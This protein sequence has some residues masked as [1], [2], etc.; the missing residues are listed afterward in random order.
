MEQALWLD[1]LSSILAFVGLGSLV[2]CYLNYKPRWFDC[3]IFAV[4]FFVFGWYSGL[5]PDEATLYQWLTA[6]AFAFGVVVL[7]WLKSLYL[8]KTDRNNIANERRLR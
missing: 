6:A 8:K 2:V 3:V 5:N 1:A 7:A 4:L